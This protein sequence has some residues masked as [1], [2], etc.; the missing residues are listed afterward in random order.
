MDGTKNG[1]Y[2]N[3]SIRTIWGIAKS[4]ELLIDEENLYALI[5]RETGK[6]HM[7]ELNQGE[8]NNMCRLLYNMKDSAKGEKIAAQ[9][10]TDEGGNSKTIKLRHKIYALTGALGWNNDN[11]RIDA[12]VKKETG[13]ESIKWL[14]IVQCNNVIEALKNMVE[15]KAKSEKKSQ[16][17]G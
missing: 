14:S 10:R 11:H 9:A 17:S 1:S 16:C 3:F 15:Q 7:K 5:L 12:F 13:I 6:A 2:G 4:P 8:I